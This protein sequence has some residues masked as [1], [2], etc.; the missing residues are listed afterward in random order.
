M[1][2][3]AGPWVSTIIKATSQ[4]LKGTMILT[5]NQAINEIIE[6]FPELKADYIESLRKLSIIM[7]RFEEGIRASQLVLDRSN[8]CDDCKEAP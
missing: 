4:L 5:E 7:R 6:E 8:M 2:G 1:D 3:I